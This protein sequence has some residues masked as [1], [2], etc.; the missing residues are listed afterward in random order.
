MTESSR[1]GPAG[2]EP[3][4]VTAPVIA[5]VI[6]MTVVAV[7]F[8]GFAVNAFVY[9]LV[10]GLPLLAVVAAGLIL[11]A[12][13]G[14]QLGPISGRGSA[15]HPARRRLAVV[16]QGLLV[17]VPILAYGTA[18][19]GLVGFLGGGL[20]LVLRDPWRW[21]GLGTI[22]AAAGALAASYT[23][24]P[25]DAVYVAVLT[26]LTGLI[27][28]GL[29]RLAELVRGVAAARSELAE[30]AVSEERLVLA[31]QL[32]ELLSDR[33]ST[34]ALNTEL[35][36]RLAGRTERAAAELTTVIEIARQALTDVRSVSR[37]FRE[38]SLPA[39][40]ESVGSLFRDLGVTFT[41]DDTAGPLDPDVGAALVA[42]LRA[43]VDDMLLH[44][45]PTTCAV[46]LRRVGSTIR[47]DLVNDGAP[48]RDADAGP[49]TA[50]GGTL[51]GLIGELEMTGSRL[52][53][54]PVDGGRYRLRAELPAGSEPRTATDAPR[55]VRRVVRAAAAP[56]ELSLARVLLVAVLAGY[57]LNAAVFVVD[58]L[59]PVEAVVAL[60]C[61]GGVLALQLAYFSR[62]GSPMRRLPG[63]AR[64]GLLLVQAALVFG[65]KLIFGD[66]ML[67]LPGF[68]AASTL[69]VL[70]APVSWIAFGTVVALAVGTQFMFG[71]G[72]V[73]VVFGLVSTVNQGLVVY[74]FT[75]LRTL[76]AVLHDARV[77]LAR[78]AVT[79]ERLRFARDLHDLL[80]YSLTAITLKAELG[81]RLLAGGAT[82][83]AV[84]ELRQILG[85]VGGALADLRTVT[86]SSRELDL[87]AE[88]S[89]VVSVLV[90]ADVDVE[91]CNELDR[92][93]AAVSTTLATVL[94]ESVTNLLRHSEAKTCRITL[95]CDS[96][97]AVL[98][99]EN[100]GAPDTP[101]LIHG[102]GLT[103]LADRV[104]A[105]S[106]QLEAGVAAERRYR[107]RVEVPLAEPAPA[108]PAA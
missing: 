44:S 30:L 9:V 13:V 78:R 7:V 105:V 3:S 61:L 40:L 71:G 5:P 1:S 62:I 16:A 4:P 8:A 51:R 92:P 11:V 12:S 32:N 49:D 72:L 102:S 64:G 21:I 59:A 23:A 80:G 68:V 56:M 48:A 26:T 10:A 60:L 87:D 41:V 70:G 76:V 96:G 77:D 43:G 101:S 65:P 34:I 27:V 108:Q 97:T 104:R 35:T 100:D 20:L 106:G 88:L 73:G 81:Q 90:A 55:Q 54:G 22:S 47:F 107:V 83:V 89:S 69:L 95:E 29:S 19:L 58:G 31:G 67:S 82:E 103:N 25:L 42:V 75:R 39:E 50:A 74:G 38:L 46:T 57:C 99:V 52:T 53:A 66:A 45:S 94:R 18:W 36:L 28:F 33:L 2:G 86:G 24:N 14:L 79:E 91:V 17:T 6:A 15:E 84:R 93:P 98:L 37:S 85:I 63:V